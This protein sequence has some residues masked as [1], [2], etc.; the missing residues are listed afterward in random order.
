[1]SAV[2]FGEAVGVVGSA[3]QGEYGALTLRADGTFTY[4]VNNANAEVQALRTAQETLTDTFSY[5]MRDAA[6]A[7]STST[8]SIVI[9]GANDRPRAVA[10]TATAE[11]QGV[12]SAGSPATGNVL[13]NDTD[14]DAGD[15]ML[16][17]GAGFRRYER[18][19]GFGAQRSLRRP[20]AA[21]RTAASLTS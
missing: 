10:D 9:Q 14:V 2:S 6:G 16:R 7:T 18:R 5:T 20:D 17:C 1:V 12:S 21:Q 8:V 3:Q 15:R 11:E 13:L 19:G 4:V